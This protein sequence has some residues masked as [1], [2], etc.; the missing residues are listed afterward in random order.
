MLRL[1]LAQMR[2]SL[3]RLSAAAVAVA[4]G[5]A[6]LAATLIA[7]GVITRTG[8]DALTATY[9]QADVVVRGQLTAA[10]RSAVRR[11]PQV[12]ATAVLDPVTLELRHDG[13]GPRAEPD[14]RAVGPASRLPDDRRR[15]RH[16]PRP[17]RSPCPPRPP[18]RSGSA[19]GTASRSRSLGSAGE[20]RARVPGR[21][22]HRRPAHA[23]SQ[24]G[25]AGLVTDADAATVRR[26]PRPTSTTTLVAAADGV[27]AT[28]AAGALSPLVGDARALTKDEAAAE[29]VSE[30]SGR[31]ERAGH[32]GA[33]VRG[34]RHARRGARHREHVPGARR[35]AHPDARDAPLRRCEQAAAAPVRAA[36]GGDPRSR[37]CARRA[38]AGR[39][40]GPGGA[41][42]PQPRRPRRAAPVARSRITPAVVL[43]PLLV[44]T[45]V[46]VLAS[47][48]PARE[49]TRVAPIA[50]LRPADAPAVG[51]RAGRVRL[52]V[53]L[54]LV[55]G[56]AGVLLL[57][58]VAGARAAGSSSLLLGVGMLAGAVSFVGVLLGA[59]FWVPR[60]VALLGR[61]L[62]STGTSARI[63]AANTVR[64]P[65][66]TAATSTALLIGVTLVVMMSTG[67]ASA[68]TTMNRG[69]RRALPGRPRRRRPARGRLACGWTR[70]PSGGPW[71]ACTGSATV[72]AVRTAEVA[73]G[74]QRT[75][76]VAAVDDG[77]LADGGARRRWSTASPTAPSSC[78]RG[79]RT[80]TPTGDVTVSAIDLRRR[81]DAGRRRARRCPSA[82]CR[83]RLGGR[84]GLVTTATLDRIAPDAPVSSHVGV[85]RPRRRS[86]PGA[87]GRPRRPP[88]TARWTSPAPPPSASATTGSST[89]CSGS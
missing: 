41:H 24:S 12:A 29:A 46:T 89:R 86:R 76:V 53:S 59:V 21:R 81:R 66:R 65:R 72:V 22:H 3:G 85:A 36:R 19:S 47:L 79:P 61:G 69:A 6:F 2:R 23:W 64:N 20:R 57:T 62:A 33:R 55:V 30:L 80:A 70:S 5:S 13:T 87:A 88:A 68:R 56:G 54:V 11:D 67:A 38:R 39:R 78:P 51:A 8:Y 74:R 16:P 75:I 50:A 60:I 44:G 82:R 28:D 52:A 83:P 71:T 49:A 10:E 73:L 14:H 35:A 48:V 32:G 18:P 84:D 9:G 42:R 31:R 43:V 4:I 7:G 40:A 34:G 1:T 17:A 45:L 77:A 26:R 25:G 63:A 27:T 58:A 15:A 37:V